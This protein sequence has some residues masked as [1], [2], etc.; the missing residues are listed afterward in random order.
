MWLH[1]IKHDRSRVLARMRDDFHH[2][3]RTGLSGLEPGADRARKNPA[4]WRDLLGPCRHARRRAVNHAIR[5]LIPGKEKGGRNRPEVHGLKARAR[6][7]LFAERLR[8]VCANDRQ[9]R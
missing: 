2:P 8:L 3:Q 5:R 1:E 6:Q 7:R 9:T 4:N